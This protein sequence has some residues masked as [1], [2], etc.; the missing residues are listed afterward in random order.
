M[1]REFL[2]IFEDWADKYDTSVTGHDEEYKEVFARY[3]DIL[4]KVADLSVGNV[5][6]FGVGTGNLTTKLLGNRLEVFGVEPSKPMR[7]LAVEKLGDSVSISDGDFLN[8]DLPN[9]SVHTIVSTYAFHHLTDAEK[10]EA[11]RNYGNFLPVGG[12]I[13]FADTMFEDK[14]AYTDTIQQSKEKGYHNLAEDLQREYYTTIG[15]LRSI[16]EKYD[17]D[18]EFTRFN[19]FVWVM[20]ATKR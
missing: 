4:Q 7:D 15:V 19:H 6:E 14:K 3:E 20:N 12:K 13:V 11:V 2:D 16:L 8:F 18:V 10:D 5:L 9:A 17:F 1:G